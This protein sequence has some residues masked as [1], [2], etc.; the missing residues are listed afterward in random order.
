MRIFELK[1]D[2]TIAGRRK[3]HSEDLQNLY[4]SPNIIRM[5]DRACSTH[6]KRGLHIGYWWE[7]QKKSEH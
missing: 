5:M 6:G 1:R 2:E 3:L 4:F 7:R